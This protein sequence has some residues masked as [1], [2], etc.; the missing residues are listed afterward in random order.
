MIF[1]YSAYPTQITAT[2]H[3]ND[4]QTTHIKAQL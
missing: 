4:S 3:D 1:I 2:E